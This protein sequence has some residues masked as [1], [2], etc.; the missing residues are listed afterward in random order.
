MKSLAPEQSADAALGVLSH[1]R[2]QFYDCLYTRADALFE[3]TDAVLCCGRSGHLAGRADAHGRAPARTRS[4]VRRGQS[5]L[6][7]A[8]PPA[9]AAGLHAA[10]ACRRRADRARGRCE[11]LAAA[12]RPHQPG[13]AVLPRLRARAAARIS[14]SPA[15]PT[16]S[17]PPW[18][19]DAPPGPPC[20][21]RSGWGRPT[22][23]PRSPPPSSAT[24]SAR[25]VRAGQWRPGDADILD[26]HGL[27]LRRHPP[28]LRPGRPARRAGRSAAL[29]PGHAP[30]RRPAPLHPARRAAPQAR[31]RSSPSPSRTPGTPPTRPR[32]ARTTRYGTAEALAWDR[33]HPRLTARGPWLDHCGE[34]PLIHGTLIRLKVE[35]LP[36]DRDPPS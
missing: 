14:S 36:G 29:G 8:A 31:R 20:W 25:L 26:R 5:R 17:S 21:T 12:R 23:P 34:L 11:Q 13:P 1:F 7:G 18:R 30:R 27:R 28:R 35:H 15:G 10:A 16:P 2:V 19:R 33:M 9:Q 3:L 32:P 6:A 4:D 22:T 24:W